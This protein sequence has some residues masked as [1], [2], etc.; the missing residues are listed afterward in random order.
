MLDPPC[1]WRTIAHYEKGDY[2]PKSPRREQI[3][4]ILNL[5][6]SNAISVPQ[7]GGIGL[8]RH[9][10]VKGLLAI[11]SEVDGLLSRV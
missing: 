7:S 3:M 9:E 2:K 5:T 8:P 1:G 4:D 6:P 10:L 11:R